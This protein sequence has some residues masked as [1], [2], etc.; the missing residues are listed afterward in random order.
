MSLTTDS[1]SEKDEVYAKNRRLVSLVDKYRCE[2]NEA[3]L[4]IRDL[5]SRLLVTADAQVS[6]LISKV[7]LS[8]FTADA[9]VS[10]LISKVELSNF[11]ADAEV[12]YLISQ[13]MHR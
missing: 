3:H 7:E 13:L 4:E 9:Q 6:Y 12:S 11:T 8:N 5:K 10:Y 2:L 1:E